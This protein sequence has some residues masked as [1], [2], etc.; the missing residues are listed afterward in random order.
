MTNLKEPSFPYTVTF[1]K[2]E[3]QIGIL[4]FNGPHMIFSGDADESAKVFFDS[5]YKEFGSRLKRERQIEREKCAEICEK[6]MEIRE[7]NTSMAIAAGNCADEI[8]A[9]GYDD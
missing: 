5:L 1:M 4:D 7:I 6:H 2:N 9:R 3:K 8:R